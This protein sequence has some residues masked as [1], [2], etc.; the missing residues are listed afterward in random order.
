MAITVNTNVPAMTAERY[1]NISTEKLDTSMERL[2]SGLR[3]NSAKDDAAGMQISN[4]LMAQ[5]DGLTVAVRNAND[6]ISMSQTAEGAMEES[7]SILQRMRDLALQ[8]SNGSNGTE[9]RKA[10]QQEVVALKDELNRI[11]ETTSFGGARLLN[12]TYGTRAFQIG[13]D[14]GEAI[15]MEFNNVRADEA[16]MGGAT[17]KATVAAS[18]D[19]T[20]W[21]AVGGKSLSLKITSAD[22]TTTSLT[23][24]SK[25]GDDIEEVATY[26]NGQANGKIS[27]SVTENGELQFVAASGASV[28]FTGSLATSL[29]IAGAK[30]VEETVQNIDVSTV[31]G[32]QRAV[33]LL[34]NSM[35][36]IDSHRAELG[37]GQN[38]LSYAIANLDNINENVTASFGRIR[39]VDFAK[40]T[41]DLTK[42][43][44]MQQA[45][46]SILAQAKQ[47]PS[48]ALSLLG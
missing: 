10:I 43:Q 24:S 7:S 42:Y 13:A 25:A 33:G 46:V 45:G 1:L 47:A 44:I 36:Y 18:I 37:A 21:T 20:E 11:A 30:K 15:F 9:E 16:M 8:S 2:A 40:E 48:V 14:A 32:S 27:A 28:V 34:D 12:G 29:G 22:G 4:R 38:R 41:T 35:Q 39:D 26:I 3:I 5:S 17:Y 31:G 23:I 6:G 19:M